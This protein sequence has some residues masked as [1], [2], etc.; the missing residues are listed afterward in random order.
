MSIQTPPPSVAGYSSAQ[1]CRLTRL[2]YRQLEYWTRTGL[3]RP[4]VREAFGS[5]SA[6]RWSDDDVRLLVI[7]RRAIDAG[8]SVQ[9]LRAAMPMIRDSEGLRWLLIGPETIVCASGSLEEL[10]AEA[11]V[12]TVIDLAE[13][14][15]AES[16]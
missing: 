1:V 14:V 12:A 16:A 5:G 2:T 13:E 4:S 7:M 3:V 9:R 8:V 15:I 6:R 10:A 11:K